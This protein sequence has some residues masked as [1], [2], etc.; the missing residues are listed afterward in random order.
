MLRET[1]LEN[2]EGTKTINRTI[3]N[4]E[5]I[6]KSIR[7]DSFQ[8]LSVR[9]LHNDELEYA[10]ITFQFFI[11]RISLNVIRGFFSIHDYTVFLTF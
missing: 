2:T 9:L 7:E 4:Y 5:T 10:F 6:I 1:L 3:S 11:Y 8:K